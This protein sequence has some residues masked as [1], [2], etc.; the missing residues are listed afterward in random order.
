MRLTIRTY[1]SCPLLHSARTHGHH[2]RPSRVDDL[3]VLAGRGRSRLAN[4]ARCPPVGGGC[5]RRGHDSGGGAFSADGAEHPRGGR[6]FGSG[7]WFGAGNES[8]LPVQAARRNFGAPGACPLSAAQ[9]CGPVPLA[10]VL[11]GLGVAFVARALHVVRLPWPRFRPSRACC[12]AGWCFSPCSP[13]APSAFDSDA[14]NGL[15]RSS[16]GSASR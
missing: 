1:R 2:R 11:A 12:R 15:V 3:I 13:T 14:D 6:G 7:R 4:S 9:R 8:R 5:V 10:L 16:P